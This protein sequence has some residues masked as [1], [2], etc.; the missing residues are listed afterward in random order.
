MLR[1]G[2]GSESK[3]FSVRRKMSFS[4]LLLGF[5]VAAKVQLPYLC[6][7]FSLFLLA[8]LDKNLLYSLIPR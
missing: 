7:D 1:F 3:N 4:R 5:G 2:R 8:F 6:L